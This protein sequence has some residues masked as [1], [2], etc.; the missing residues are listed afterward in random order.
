MSLIKLKNSFGTDQLGFISDRGIMKYFLIFLWFIFVEV[1]FAGRGVDA[2][3]IKSTDHTKTWT[4]PAATDTLV[5]RSSTDTLTNK[6]INGSL[7]S[8]TNVDLTTAV[9]GILPVANGGTGRSTLTSNNLLLGNGTGTVSFIP[10]GANGT[11]LVVSGGV[12]TAGTV[13]VGGSGDILGPASSISGEAVIFNS[14]TGKSIGRA[15]G[16]GI[17]RLNSGVLTTSTGISLSTEVS[18]A[19][20][21]ANGGTGQTTKAAGFD[22][23][24]PNTT[25]GDITAHNGTNNARLAVGSDGQVLAADSSASTGVRWTDSS[26]NLLTNP[27]F[28]AST[29]STGWTA[30]G[31]T[32]ATVETVSVG[33]GAKAYKW[34]GA[35]GEYV[36]S[37]AV[38]IPKALYG[39]NGYA[40][41]RIFTN[42]ATTGSLAAVEVYNGTTVIASNAIGSV[43]YSNYT[44]VPVNFVFPSSGSISLRYKGG[45]G[46]FVWLDDAF[47][48][49]ALNLSQVNQ[50]TWVGSIKYSGAASCSW[51]VNSGS[52]INF[53]ADTDCS[54]PTV[55]GSVTAPGT[56][57]PGL[58]IPSAAS[59]TYLFLVRGMMYGST[60]TEARFRLS[61]GTN[62]SAA[63]TVYGS[64]S[65][66][67]SGGG[68]TGDITL[69]SATSN[70]TVQMQ[71]LSAGSTNAVI[72][73]TA[74]NNSFEISVYRFPSVYDTA[75]NLSQATAFWSGYH[76]TTCG[77][78]RTNT[79]LGAFTDDATC[80]LVQGSNNSGISCVSSG[81][82]SP[83]I[84]C[85][86]PRAGKYRVKAGFGSFTGT[87][88]ATATLSLTDGTNIQDQTVYQN[89]TG[90]YSATLDGQ[91]YVSGTSATFS[92][93]GATSSGS[94]SITGA[95]PKRSS[96]EWTVED[97]SQAANNPLIIGSVS[98]NSSGMERIERASI[99]NTSGGQGVASQSGS[100]LSASS[101]SG[102]GVCTYAITSG[103][104]SASPVCVCS[105]I[106]SAS[107]ICQVTG[108]TST[109]V[110]V[111]TINGSFVAANEN[112]V[113]LICMGPR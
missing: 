32:S 20:A 4:P 50:A 88:D 113:P 8:I 15:T 103:I 106:N 63:S 74:T 62:S 60:S 84:S 44:L 107:A 9:T 17:A 12:W 51:S 89:G 10:P 14:T 65:I 72:D 34:A 43:T 46:N 71:G 105:S 98:S 94:L 66:L 1:A 24:S 30:S 97:I 77:W 110:T 3:F 67:V 112:G 7:N 93:Q 96:I 48:G 16:T 101:C 85:T 109:S 95:S 45:N 55:A 79:A 104:F 87:S 42:G 47:L 78:S 90:W 29:F 19:L 111:R 11:A 99:N 69:A 33:F 40:Y 53:S 57:I 21:I 23:L 81:S 54:T 80:A 58:V 27:G 37:T 52:F 108:T 39:Q 5:G 100:W 22:A 49:S 70:W 64:S 61:D 18:G 41:I 91:F 35:G 6:T 86:F 28:E 31:A 73:N 13:S 38:T 83:A 36:T 25:K 102:T 26:Q 82:V 75:F 2:D 92:V 68:L 56:K 59:G 76:D